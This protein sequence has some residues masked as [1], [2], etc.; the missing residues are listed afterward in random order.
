MKFK[1]DENLPDEVVGALRAAGHDAISI[2]TQDLSGTDDNTIAARITQEERCL[3]TLDLGFGDIRAYP[4]T[5][6]KGIIAVRAKRQDKATVLS[7]VQRLMPRLATEPIAGKLW[8]V[9]E[10]RI[11][12]RGET[13]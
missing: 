4:P 1:V 8:I 11:R 5:A 10:D 2:A 7:L 6:Y 9:E 12:I 3:V 13:G